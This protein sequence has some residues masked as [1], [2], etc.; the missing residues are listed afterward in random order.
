MDYLQTRFKLNRATKGSDLSTTPGPTD[1]YVNE[2]EVVTGVKTGGAAGGPTVYF[3][4][5]YE[6]D[7]WASTHKVIHPMAVT[8][9]ELCM[10]NATYATMVKN[11]WPEAKVTGF[12]SYGYN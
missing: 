4:L 5:V 10:R 1:G 8:Y 3:A 12:V 11:V 6:P 7:L 2:V 9:D